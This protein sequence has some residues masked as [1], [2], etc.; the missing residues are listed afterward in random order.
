M[1]KTILYFKLG[2]NLQVT[3]DQFH[4]I[5][6]FEVKENMTDNNAVIPLA[7]RILSKNKVF[8]WSFDKGYFSKE[9]KE[10]LALFIGS[11]IK[12]CW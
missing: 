9:N 4:L 8:S 11:F 6:D 3:T 1:Q 12:E 5:I 2:K 7:D 10:L